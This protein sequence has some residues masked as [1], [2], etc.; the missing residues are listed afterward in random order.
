MIESF[1]KEKKKNHKKHNHLPSQE[2]VF[3]PDCQAYL[4]TRSS[5]SSTDFF[6]V[7]LDARNPFSC[8]YTQFEESDI[9]KHIF[10]LNKIDLVPRE[11]AISWLKAMKTIAPTIAISAV[12]DVTPLT[13]FII[14]KTQSS[15]RPLSFV[16]TGVAK[17]GKHTIINQLPSIPNATITCTQPW[18]WL[19]QTADLVSIGAVDVQSIGHKFIDTARDFLYRCSIH[20]L[21]AVFN[22]PFFSDADI[23]LTSLDTNKRNSALKLLTGLSQATYHFY[24]MPQ[25]KYTSDLT[26]DIDETQRNAFRFS[27][28]YDMSPQPYI[29]LGYGTQNRIK[30]SVFKKLI[31]GK[32]N[33]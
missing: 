19:Q 17:T 22:V 10:V 4:S 1:R 20:S 23:V 11:I 27:I 18:T 8:R 9:S 25:S 3:A 12:H 2:N 26:D 29:F 16:L 21:M 13:D 14:S 24:T 30:V 6:I 15:D 31:K 28:P 5:F 7:I 33:I 32:N